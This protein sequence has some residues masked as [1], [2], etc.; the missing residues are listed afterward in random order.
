MSM[1]FSTNCGKH[2]MS[3]SIILHRNG[4]SFINRNEFGPSLAISSA[5]IRA[6]FCAGKK[7][8]SFTLVGLA[9]VG[10]LALGECNPFNV[11]EVYNYIFTY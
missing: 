9:F 2:V 4:I 10:L 6:I 11:S 5:A 3:V 8:K 7:M 1:N